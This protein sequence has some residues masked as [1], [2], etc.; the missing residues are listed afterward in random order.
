MCPNWSFLLL[1]FLKTPD[2]SQ[3]LISTPYTIYLRGITMKYLACILISSCWKEL[4]GCS[5]NAISVSSA[6]LA[7]SIFSKLSLLHYTGDRKY[8]QREGQAAVIIRK[9]IRWSYSKILIHTLLLVPWTFCYGFQLICRWAGCWLR[10]IRNHTWSSFHSSLRPWEAFFC[11]F[12][13]S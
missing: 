8:T 11:S 3:N 10:L 2:L 4:Y 5:Q 13:C 12:S 1:F 9:W 6:V 7:F